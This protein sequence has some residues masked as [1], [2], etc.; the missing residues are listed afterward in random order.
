M[1]LLKTF[2]LVSFLAVCKAK[3]HVLFLLVVHFSSYLL[4]VVAMHKNPSL[5]SCA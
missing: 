2:L 3:S 4:K 5:D 1:G